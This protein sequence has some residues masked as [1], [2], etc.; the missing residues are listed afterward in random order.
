MRERGVPLDRKSIQKLLYYLKRN[1]MGYG[2]IDALLKDPEIE[3]ISCDGVGVPIYL[4]HREFQNIRS[5]IVFEDDRELNLFVMRLAERAGRQISL[6][7]PAVD[8][9]LPEGF[10]LQAT[11]GTE[12]TAKGSSFSIRKFAVEPFTPIDL[13]KYK[14]FSP[15]MLAY[16][17][18]ATENRKN[19]MIVGGTASG[20][21]STLNALSLFIPP[22]AKIISIEDTRELTL[23]QENWLASV[24]REVSE[25]KSIEMYDLLRSALRQRPEIIIVGEVRGKEALTLFQAMSTGHTS[26]STMHAG[27]IPE[28]VHRLEAEPINVP[29]HMLSALNIVCLQLLTYYQDK[30]VRRNQ[31]IVE[32][33]G[34]DPTSGALRLNRVYERNPVTDHFEK[35]G[36]SQILMEIA[37]ERGW[38]MLDL[39]KELKN[40][41]RVLEYLAEKNIRR[42]GEVSKIIRSYYFDPEG[43][44]KQIS[45]R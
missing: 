44:M 25:G 1:Y 10:R 43:V 20:K 17:W 15:E 26:Y 33:L 30:R 18:L 4:Y 13:I 45:K 35:V 2:K 27:S 9:S 34:V 24:T 39:E 31:S 5:N 22:A 32:I 12:I 28:M 29:H 6:G 11:L 42:L 41:Q 16:L 19:I 8:A 37:R 21:T 3:D 38:G 7:R 14:T 36:D 40:R 23:Y